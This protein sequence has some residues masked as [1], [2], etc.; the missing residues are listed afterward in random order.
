MQNDFDV[1]IIGSGPAGCSAAM[2]LARCKH[3]TLVIDKGDG[4]SYLGALGNIS[5]FPGFPESVT[6]S[7]LLAKMKKQAELEG[8]RFT[9]GSVTGISTDTNPK[10]IITDNN[11]EY[12]AKT[13]V[14]A[15]GAAARK[16][17]LGG[18][19][20]LLGKG[21]SHD[22]IADGPSVAKRHAAVVGK[23]RETAEGAIFLS[24]FA[25]K[26]YLIIPSNKLDVDEK[27]LDQ[28]QKNKSVE[29]HFSTS[30]KRING[31][32][33]VTSI[34]VLSSGQ[35]REITVSGVFTYVHEYQTTTGYLEKLLELTS[36]GS[37]KVDES[38]STSVEGVFA[39]GDVLCARPQLPAIAS[40][41]GVLAGVSADKY[42]SL[43]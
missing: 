15:T 21:V 17:Y 18:E 12:T 29:M 25:E 28:L 14:V 39:C 37:I 8:V 16:N 11:D 36:A 32:D 38:M 19:R 35:E 5:C 22:A 40:A 3:K 9:R 7:E 41:Q 6:G 31:K 10:R 33:N 4:T 20:E 2:F 13:I 43:L 26:V 23:N 24:R 34:S 30:I 1:I 27:L 42:L